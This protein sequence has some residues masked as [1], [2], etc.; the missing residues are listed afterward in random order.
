MFVGVVTEAREKISVG[1]PR[2]QPEDTSGI[3]RSKLIQG[4][5]RGRLAASL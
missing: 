5:M 4:K 1:R 3:G 2:H